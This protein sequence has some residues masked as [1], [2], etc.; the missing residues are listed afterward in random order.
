MI[1]MEKL[2]L[3]RTTIYNSG[4]WYQGPIGVYSSLVKTSPLFNISQFLPRAS[5]A[6][7]VASSRQRGEELLNPI[8]DPNS[9]GPLSCTWHF[10]LF[11]PPYSL[12]FLHSRQYE[13]DTLVLLE[14]K[15]DYKGCNYW[16]TNYSTLFSSQSQTLLLSSPMG[17]SSSTNHCTYPQARM[18][19]SESLRS[20]SLR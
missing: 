13:M 15:K 7:A 6:S 9:K 4:L 19:E 17:T 11:L 20:S 16:T 18:I 2:G 5:R 3:L 14:H 1:K 8:G 10:S 12:P